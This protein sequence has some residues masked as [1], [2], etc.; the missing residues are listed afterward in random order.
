[1]TKVDI[2][3]VVASTRTA[4]QFCQ[5]HKVSAYDVI[6]ALKIEVV[7]ARNYQSEKSLKIQT[8]MESSMTILKNRNNILVEENEKLKEE[9][10]DIRRK[11]TT[12]IR[13]DE[14]MEKNIDFLRRIIER[15][16]R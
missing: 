7:Y 5:Y 9:L 16:I 12:T 2:N 6:N 8:E 14:Q 1:M 11:L 4:R 15:L 13:E 3:A 10:E